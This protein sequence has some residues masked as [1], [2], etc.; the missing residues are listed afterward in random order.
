MKKKILLIGY[1]YHPE[2]TGI[3]KYSGEMINWLSKDGYDC[4]VITA[5]PY[6]PYWKVQEPY[7]KHRFWYQKEEQFCSGGKITIYRCPIYVPSKPSGMKRMLLDF[8]FMITAA[9]KLMQL[10][11]SNKFDFVFVIAPSFQFGLLGILYKKIR[12]SYLVYHI[13]DMQIEAARDLKLIKSKKLIKFLFI[14]EKYILKKS[15]NVTTISPSMVQKVR[16]KAKKEVLL[17]PNW[18]DTKIFFPIENRAALKKMFGFSELHKIILYSG[19]IGEKQGLDAI[20]QSA[21]AY[22]DQHDLKFVICGSGPYKQKLKNLVEE[23]DL[24]NVIFFPLQSLDKFNKFLNMADLHLVI[25]KSIASDLVMPSKLTTILAIGGLAL[26]TAD[27][28]SSLH[29]LVTKYKMGLLVKSESQ[30]ALNEGIENAIW[31]NQHMLTQNARAYAE[32]F[33]SIDRVMEKLKCDISL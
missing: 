27:D 15:D 30:Q 10:L 24:S 3:G 32:S 18:V 14:V 9:C 12:K 28:D 20:I 17:F 22:K 13:Q 2:L 23:L 6:Y 7:A 25:Q 33:L 1:N 16:E 29:N 21:Y 19:A 31:G 4:T 8:S 5:Y 26:I 11:F